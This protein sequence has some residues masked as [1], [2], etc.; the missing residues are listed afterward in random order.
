M[1]GY[2]G[3]DPTVRYAALDSG[4]CRLPCFGAELEY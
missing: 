4:W 2:V 3:D 1:T